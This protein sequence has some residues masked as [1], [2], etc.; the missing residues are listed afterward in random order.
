MGL[1]TEVGTG[2]VTLE[3]AVA[4]TPRIRRRINGLSPNASPVGVLAV[5]NSAAA[6]LSPLGLLGSV[7]LGV[8]VLVSARF[9]PGSKLMAVAVIA[10]V[11]MATLYTMSIFGR[12]GGK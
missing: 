10:F 5:T 1:I 2:P 3:S 4:M 12:M 9:S 7:I 6:V 11:V 8:I